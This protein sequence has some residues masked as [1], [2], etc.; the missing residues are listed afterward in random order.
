MKK[1]SAFA[2]LSSGFIGGVALLVGCG[3]EST[4]SVVAAAEAAWERM[5][6]NIYYTGGNVGIGT[7]NPNS[8]LHIADSS[9]TI[10][11]SV[12]NNSNHIDLKLLTRFGPQNST[13]EGGHIEIQGAGNHQDWFIDSYKGTLRFIEPYHSRQIEGKTRGGFLFSVK[14]QSVTGED[15][16]DALAIHNSG[17]V[18]IGKEEPNSALDVAGYIQL[19]TTGG[20]V[21]PT[22]DCNEEKERGRMTI[23][24][25]SSLLYICTASGWVAK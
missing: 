23:D 19:K 21:P 3:G 18:G 25:I 24:A 8:K 6:A 10:M 5:G 20:Q 12:G 16:I 9:S 22:G 13:N 15:N 1:F 11:E 17:R 2:Y 14:P 7:D 4:N